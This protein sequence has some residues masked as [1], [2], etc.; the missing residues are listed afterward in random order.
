MTP[1]TEG[2][3]E[4]DDS[5]SVNGV[6]RIRIHGVDIDKQLKQLVIGDGKAFTALG[7][8]IGSIATSS[9]STGILKSFEEYNRNLAK[10]VAPFR[11][12]RIELERTTSPIVQAVQDIA[13]T[14]SWASHWDFRDRP[15]NWPP[16]LETRKRLEV[17]SRKH[18]IAL[19]GFPSREHTVAIAACP[20]VKEV[21]L[22][23]TS[24]LEAIGDDLLKTVMTKKYKARLKR[25][26]VEIAAS[27]KLGNIMAAQSLSMAVVEEM[28]S[29]LTRNQKTDFKKDVAALTVDIVPVEHYGW[30]YVIE[31]LKGVMVDQR[32][33]RKTEPRRLN[34]NSIAHSIDG[35]QYTPKNAAR[36][37]FLAFSLVEVWVKSP[38]EL[39]DIL[40]AT[41]G[42]ENPFH[43]EYARSKRRQDAKLSKAAAEKEERKLEA[44]RNKVRKNKQRGVSTPKK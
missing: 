7:E 3:G 27:L 21:N 1:S 2:P 41:A 12:W 10:A 15:T 31:S 44:A 13:K 28:G 17:L 16:G 43:I 4:V 9:I 38:K 5:R 22:Y 40:A 8:R 37:A 34:R 36:A 20:T 23:L 18:S 32:E 19:Y 24:N 29:V 25:P 42:L 39:K 11:A 35:H 14:F 33:G 26:L 30:G 6:P